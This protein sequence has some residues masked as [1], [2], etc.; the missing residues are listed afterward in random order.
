MKDVPWWRRFQVY[1]ESIQNPG[2][3]WHMANIW[4]AFTA[5]LSGKPIKIYG[6]ILK[7][8]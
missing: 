7:T 5:F 8:K 4:E 2:M 6:R 3:S 1:E